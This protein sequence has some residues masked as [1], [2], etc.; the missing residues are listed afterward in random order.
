MELKPED[1]EQH[2][3]QQLEDER[4]WEKPQ[5]SPEAVARALKN[6]A[7]Y[8]EGDQGFNPMARDPITGLLLHPREL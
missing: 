8:K 7:D 3:V 1:L 2:V 6:A 5:L 4:A